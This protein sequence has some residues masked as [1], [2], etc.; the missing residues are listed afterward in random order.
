MWY[1]SLPVV[2]KVNV[3]LHFLLGLQIY[4][5][6]IDEISPSE[7]YMYHFYPRF[8]NMMGTESGG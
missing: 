6:V 1:I 4:S 7:F 5:V 3:I 2:L 8:S